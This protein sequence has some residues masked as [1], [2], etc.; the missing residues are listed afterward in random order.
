MHK[1]NGSGI[2]GQTLEQTLERLDFANWY[3]PANAAEAEGLA[4]LWE[5]NRAERRDVPGKAFP[6]Y[7]L[8]VHMD[9]DT[10]RSIDIDD[11]Y[12][13]EHGLLPTGEGRR[14]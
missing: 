7:R 13:S 8:M 14:R 11:G 6:E 3:E 1:L 2:T 10:E 5:A 4:T 9:P 12:R